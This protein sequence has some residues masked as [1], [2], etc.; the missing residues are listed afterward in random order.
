MIPALRRI[1]FASPV[2]GKLLR[3]EIL[4]QVP[5][6][7]GGVGPTT[8]TLKSVIVI[9]CRTENKILSEGFRDATS[10]NSHMPGIRL[11]LLDL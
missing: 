9:E 8:R 10:G 5:P 3:R 2:S 1:F 6:G 11:E 4:T 7:R